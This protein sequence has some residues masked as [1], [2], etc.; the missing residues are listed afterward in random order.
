[1]ADIHDIR[2][3]NQVL[4]N[5]S[6]SAVTILKVENNKVLL[7]TFPK[8]SYWLVTEI[9]G[10]PLTTSILQKLLF[11]NDEQYD[12][13]RGQGI[14][15]DVKSDGFFYGLRISKSKTK[16][17]YLHQLQNY[18]ADFYTVFR[19]QKHCLDVSMLYK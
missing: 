18:I 1:M 7:D 9:S 17:Q 10:I 19:Q 6:G 8:S 2:D 5:A 15:I 4:H 11:T 14:G 13:W 3:G 16:I 12:T